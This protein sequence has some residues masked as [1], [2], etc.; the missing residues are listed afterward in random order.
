MCGNVR[1]QVCSTA[2]S[3]FGCRLQNKSPLEADRCVRRVVTLAW[4]FATIFY[5]SC[6]KGGERE[7]KK[8][9][10]QLLIIKE[11]TNNNNND[12]NNVINNCY[13]HYYYKY[14][15]KIKN[16]K[17]EYNNIYFIQYSISHHHKIKKQQ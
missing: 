1:K 14:K 10:T 3:V 13:H 11:E 5:Y 2:L 9:K 8:K 17:C 7:E 12:N 6:N 15:H 4:P 16:N